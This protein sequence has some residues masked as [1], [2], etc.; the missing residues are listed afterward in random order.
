MGYQEEGIK[1]YM[2]N[3]TPK[4]V[5]TGIPVAR[6]PLALGSQV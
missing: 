6:S 3:N 1:A 2:G 5:S 4:E